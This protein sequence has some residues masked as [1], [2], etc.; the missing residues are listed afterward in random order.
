MTGD[1]HRVVKNEKERADSRFATSPV[2]SSNDSSQLCPFPKQE[3]KKYKLVGYRIDL[4]R[5]PNSVA[6]RR[7]TDSAIGAR[8]PRFQIIPFSADKFIVGVGHGEICPVF[9]SFADHKFK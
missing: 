1:K 9:F 8:N 6:S 3:N 2:C 4:Y 7:A 5:W